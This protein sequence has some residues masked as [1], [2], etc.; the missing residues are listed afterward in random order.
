MEETWLQT[1]QEFLRLE[2]EWD[3]ARPVARGVT[4]QVLRA[5]ED[6]Q[7]DISAIT[8]IMSGSFGTSIG[9]C[10][11]NPKAPSEELNAKVEA[12]RKIV[13]SITRCLGIEGKKSKAPYDNT[14]LSVD[15]NSE[16][17]ERPTDENGN[18]I[19]SNS[20][21][22]CV[23]YVKHERHR[24]ATSVHVSSYVPPTCRF[25]TKFRDYPARDAGTESYTEIECG[26]EHEVIE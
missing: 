25:V 19:W 22:R 13:L 8:S 5:L 12:Q 11:L 15:W 2:R 7:C 18:T 17:R 20:D 16:A 14:S 23:E 24:C 6:D 4:L 21:P 10:P 26:P 3:K 9:F 1:R